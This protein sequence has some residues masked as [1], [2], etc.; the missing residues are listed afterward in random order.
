MYRNVMVREVSKYL[1]R[2]VVDN[3]FYV[4]HFDA[5]GIESRGLYEAV[6]RDKRHIVVNNEENT[7]TMGLEAAKRVIAQSGLSATDFDMLVFVSDSPEFLAPTTALTLR[8]HLGATNAHMVFDMNQN[9]T[10][11]V[12]GLDV[13]SQYMKTK[14]YINRALI[15]SSFYGSL[16][17]EEESDPVSCGCL[18]DGGSAVILEVEE[19]EVERGI[20]DASYLTKSETCH[21]MVFPACGVSKL[22]DPSV[23]LKDKKMAYRYEEADFL[24]PD[25]AEGI[26]ILLDR[27]NVRSNDVQHYLVSQFETAIIHEVSHI[28]GIDEDKFVTT[29]PELGYVGNSS[30]IFA[31]EKLIKKGVK[32]DDMMVLS[33]VG[34]GY[35]VSSILYKF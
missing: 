22:H 28:L 24:G 3:E 11:M 9:C 4:S 25:S 5:K 2:T 20:L 6:G 12:A 26:K 29:M 14:K 27:N 33:S 32:E 10:G 15:V 8:E 35:I 17:A 34:A 23:P 21:L 13:V 30:P 16:M 31:F 18:S 1:P 19:S 7:F